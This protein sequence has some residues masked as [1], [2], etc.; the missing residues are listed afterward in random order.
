MLKVTQWL[1]LCKKT[2]VM[3]AF[4]NPVYSWWFSVCVCVC[5]H[6]RTVFGC[7]VRNPSPLWSNMSLSFKELLFRS[8]AS[9]CS[10][11]FPCEWE[12]AFTNAGCRGTDRR[13]SNKLQGESAHTL[14]SVCVCV[15]VS[16]VTTTMAALS[17]TLFWMEMFHQQTFTRFSKSST[18]MKIR[19]II[20]CIKKW[21]FFV[22]LWQ[23]L[24]I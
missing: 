19:E 15:C 21:S 9:R 3:S 8:G 16:C 22:A 1:D 5:S 12:I 24:V 14:D 11:A 20:L 17:Q 18:R 13:Y 4:H 7:S 23:F 6:W 2:L 10:W